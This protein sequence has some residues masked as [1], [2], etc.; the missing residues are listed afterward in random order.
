M[1]V[2]ILIYSYLA[3][4]MAMIMFNIVC[5]CAF[6]QRDRKLVRYSERFTRQ[7]EM[8]I[9]LP[10]IE[11][12]HKKYL[13]KKLSKVN[14]LIA[15][16]KTLDN[17]YG[18]D[19]EK[20][21]NYIE[22]LSSVFIYLTFEYRKKNKLKAAY[23]P[24]IIAKYGVFR[25]HDI[26]IIS[27]AMVDLACDPSLYCR[28]NALNA[29]YSIGDCNSVVKALLR[30]DAS[31]NFYNIKMITDGLMKFTGDTKKLSEYFWMKLDQFSNDMRVAI[32][33][34]FRYSRGVP[35]YCERML[36]LMTKPGQDDEIC[37]SCIRYFG[38][39][40]YQPAFPYIIE[41]AKNEMADKWEY[42]A[43][44]V[45]TLVSYPCDETYNVL[46]D[47]LSSRN[48]YVRYN[49]AKSLDSLGFE[50]VD[51]VDVFEGDDRY[52]GEIMRYV[53]EEKRLHEKEDKII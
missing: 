28:E 12:R 45:S 38:K 39:Y 50:Y 20:I 41:F 42:A 8:Q 13:S 24:Y 48:W 4:C 53:L 35:K 21:R 36:E 27:D 32:L 33:N 40:V 49:A 18:E 26:N 5:I 14:N 19:P 30:L 2:E 51:L 37:Y 44:S 47:K 3:I 7:I 1:K 15:F 17:F 29:L 10:T 9:E 43:I 46:K 25:G 22:S 16:D 23:F 52:A 31:G 6:K 34:F 11:E